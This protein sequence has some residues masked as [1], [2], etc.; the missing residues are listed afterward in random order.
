[1][2]LALPLPPGHDQED[3][4]AHQRNEGHPAHNGANN[5]GQLLR[6]GGLAGVK[7]KIFY[8]KELEIYWNVA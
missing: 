1:V 5:Q 7:Q 3:E 8:I 4:Q 6:G 2:A